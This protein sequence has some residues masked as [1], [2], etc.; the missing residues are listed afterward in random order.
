MSSHNASQ[1]MVIKWL[2]LQQKENLSPIIAGNKFSG[3]LSLSFIEND[4]S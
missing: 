2:E 3:K 1:K 4:I